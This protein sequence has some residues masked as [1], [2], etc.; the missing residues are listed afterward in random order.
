[1]ETDPKGTTLGDYIRKIDVAGL[2]ICLWC[3]MKQ[4]NYGSSG[5]KVLKQHALCQ[6]HKDAADSMQKQQKMQ[7][8]T[9]SINKSDTCTM[10]YGTPL[11]V[12]GTCPGPKPKQVQPSVS[13][14]DRISHS[15]A[16]T[17]SFLA[18]FN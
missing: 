16:R 10:P 18:E 11:N 6:Q 17:V 4:I 5:K 3:N 8:L 1:M 13:I 7:S 15:E 14:M 2:C 12:H 9:T